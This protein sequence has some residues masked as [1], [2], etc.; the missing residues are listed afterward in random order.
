MILE[1]AREVIRDRVN[2]KR[3]SD[4]AYWTE[5]VKS[6]A[7]GARTVWH[8]ES[9]N[10]VW[11]ARQ[12]HLLNDAFRTLVGGVADRDVLDVGCGTGRMSRELLRVGARVTGVDFSETAVGMAKD[13]QSASDD[14]S[15]PRF[16]VGDAAKPPLPFDDCSFDVA[17]TVG[18]LAC[19]CTSIESLERSLRELYRITRP[20][21]AVVL[22]EPMHSSGLLGRMLRAPVSAWIGA[23]SRVG[24]RLVVR[25]GMG[26]VP[27]RFV[28]SSF[29]IPSWFV[30]PVFKAGEIAIDRVLPQRIASRVVEYTLLGFRRSYG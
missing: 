18:C 25:S 13:E 16:V 14:R 5:R 29:E 27:V 15:S 9:Y 28:L 19:A 23:A 22:F 4:A 6:R 11:H 12:L 20:S 26:L 24:M 3:M 10:E 2:R 1:K 17:F 7:G 21:G 30:D 8:S